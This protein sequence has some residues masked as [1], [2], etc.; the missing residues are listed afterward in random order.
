MPRHVK[1]RLPKGWEAKVSDEDL[2][3]ELSS[4]IAG[5]L[6]RGNH[7]ADDKEKRARFESRR[8]SIADEILAMDYDKH[9][10]RE[11]SFRESWQ[12]VHILAMDR[13]RRDAQARLIEE[14]RNRSYRA[15]FK[16][17]RHVL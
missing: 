14:Q 5:A 3:G 13:K 7:D 16:R 1:H 2:M 6:F 8:K 9:K 10:P 17:G 4:M 12:S 15:K 11:S